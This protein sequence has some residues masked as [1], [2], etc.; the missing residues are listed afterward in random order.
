M[1][2]NRPTSYS[3]IL[4]YNRVQPLGSKKICFLCKNPVKPGKL[5]CPS[6]HDNW[7]ASNYDKGSR[8]DYLKWAQGIWDKPQTTQPW[9]ET[10][11]PPDFS[12]LTGQCVKFFK[13]AYVQDMSTEKR[14]ALY[15]D[16]FKL[17]I[18]QVTRATDASVVFSA[19]GVCGTCSG[20][21]VDKGDY[22]CEECRGK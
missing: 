3:E 22:L 8:E 4:S 13:F 12:A 20:P 2:D 1:L 19:L 14:I 5:S 11:E 15:A 6:H 10:V 21:V 9:I 7:V 18:E 17:R 16:H